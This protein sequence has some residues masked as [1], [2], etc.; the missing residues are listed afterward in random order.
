MQEPFC[1]ACTIEPGTTTVY[2][3]AL[4]CFR[5]P[6]RETLAISLLM[7]RGNNIS[8]FLFPNREFLA[9]GKVNMQKAAVIYR[10]F[11]RLLRRI[12][13]DFRLWPTINVF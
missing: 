9:G 3:I 6:H 2:I 10:N 12:Y 7:I 13:H 8:G 11:E 1:D 4:A 5:L